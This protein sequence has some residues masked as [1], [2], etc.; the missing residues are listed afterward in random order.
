MYSTLQPGIVRLGFQGNCEEKNMKTSQDVL[1]L[2]LYAND[3]CEEELIFDEGD[4]FWRC[5]Q[6][7]HLCRWELVSRITRDEDL[8]LAVA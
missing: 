5:P 7:Q 1:E 3:C 8:E 6:C 2:G 4:T